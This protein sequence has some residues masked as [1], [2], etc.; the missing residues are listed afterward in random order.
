MLKIL[1]SHL[2][3]KIGLLVLIFSV[4]LTALIFIIVDYYYTEQDSVLDAHDLYFYSNLVDGW[5]EPLDTIKTKND[6]DNL[7]LSL[8][9]YSAEDSSLVWFYPKIIN[10]SGYYNFLDSKDLGGAY[11]INFPVFTSF[12]ESDIYANLIYVNN[13]D[14]Y[15]MVVN[16]EYFPEYINY[17]PP[18]VLSIIFMFGLNYFIRGFLAPIRK[19]EKRVALLHAGDVDT[20]IEV[21]GNDELSR[22][23]MSINKM[24][25]DIK[26]LLNQKHQLLLDVSHELRSPLARM[27]LLAEM[28]PY[29]KNTKKLIGEIVFL[30]GVI[31]NFLLSDKLSLPYSDLEYVETKTS[32]IMSEVLNILDYKSRKIK[33]NNAVSDCIMRVDKTK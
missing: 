12:G 1:T 7:H 31:A 6:L 10:P 33:I 2:F 18:I 3:Y 4:S 32:E 14:H 29:H 20:T 25:K 17:I 19:M 16:Q 11:N 15:F 23:S 22:L 21:S 26:T 24:I 30:E 27:R 9:V 28:I 8:S 5:G 13:G